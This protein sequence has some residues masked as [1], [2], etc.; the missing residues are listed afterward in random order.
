MHEPLVGRL[1]QYL[2]GERSTEVDEHL[3]AC[4]ACR[5]EV[6]AMSKQAT[7]LRVL[8]APRAAEPDPGFYARVMTRIE[9]QGRVSVWN[10]FGD[11]AFAR[12]LAFASLSF[13]VLMGTY[14]V[15]S[16]APS[17]PLTAAAPEIIMADEDQ[18]PAVGTDP[19]RDREVVLVNLAT[20]SGE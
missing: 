18:Q 9:G 3:Q 12:R 8:K 1:E 16:S 6:E 11:S 13:A 14:F 5:A 2:N 4:A 15:S 19:Q 10:I 7:L 20:Y 17:E